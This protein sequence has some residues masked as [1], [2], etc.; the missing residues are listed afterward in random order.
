MKYKDCNRGYVGQEDQQ[1]T[2]MN[3]NQPSNDIKNSLTSQG[4]DLKDS[5]NWQTGGILNQA[6]LKNAREFL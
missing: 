3:A 2:F 4:T 5:F 1:S 6:K